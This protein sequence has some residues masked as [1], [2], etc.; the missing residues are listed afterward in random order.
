MRQNNASYPPK[1]HLTRHPLAGVPK[2]IYNHL[3]RKEQVM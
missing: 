2:F 3:I 1:M